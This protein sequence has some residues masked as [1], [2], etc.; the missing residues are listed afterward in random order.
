VGQGLGKLKPGKAS[1]FILSA[2]REAHERNVAVGGLFNAYEKAVH[3]ELLTAALRKGLGA[4]KHEAYL[5]RRQYC[6]FVFPLESAEEFW[7]EVKMWWFLEHVYQSPYEMMPKTQ[8]WPVDDWERL[9]S[10]PQRGVLLI[11]TWDNDKMREKADRW[12]D[13]ITPRMKRDGQRI[14]PT[15]ESLAPAGNDPRECRREGDMLLWSTLS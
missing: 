9:R 13:E 7:L 3:Y 15:R 11:R 5:G 14:E 2:L 8:Y 1:E 10:K 6:D 4:T 12:L